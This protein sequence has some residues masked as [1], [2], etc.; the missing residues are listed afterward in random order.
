MKKVISIIIAVVLMMALATTAFAASITINPQVPTDGTDT[1]ETY[2]AYK[3]F[4]ADYAG[5]DLADDANISYTIDSTSPFF[6]A[7]SNFTVGTGEEAVKAFKLTQVNNTTKYIVTKQADYDAKDLAEAL[8]SSIPATAAGTATYDATNKNYK[9]T[10]LAKGYYLVTS[11]LGSNLIIWTLDNETVNTKNEYPSIEKKIV[12]GT[13]RVDSITA[14]RGSTVAFELTVS[15]PAS[16]VGTITVHDKM[17]DGLTYA[18]W[19]AITGITANTAPTDECDVEFVLSADYVAANKGTDIVISLTATVDGD[20]ALDKAI[21]NKTWLN[22]SNFTSKEDEVAVYTYQ[23][24]VFK[25]TLDGE[26][27][28]GLAGAGFVLMNAEGNYYKNTDGVVSWVAAE[29]DASEY[30]TAAE[31]YTVAFTGLKNGT[32]TLHEKTVPTGYNPAQD[33]DVTIN[34]ASKAGETRVEVLNETGVELPTTGGIGTRIFY[35]VG[36]T[37]MLGAAVILV[38]RKKVSTSED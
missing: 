34:G 35:V 18:G 2:K 33:V 29:A 20:A 13:D 25:Y 36:A 3:I 17:D 9:I 31:A 27:Q 7:V 30:V 11:S 26:N 28:E 6:T 4:D 14:E 23:I 24:E 22:Y 5:D 16:A 1:N 19:T 8:R 32:Y 12:D 10:G 38:A 37:L 15:I 21:K